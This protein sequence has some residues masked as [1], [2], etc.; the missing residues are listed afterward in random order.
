[1]GPWIVTRDELGRADDLRIDGTTGSVSGSTVNGPGPNT[2][3]SKAIA[4]NGIQVSNGALA[5]VIDNTVT[6]NDCDDAADGVQIDRN[7]VSGNDIGIY[8]QSRGT[9]DLRDNRAENNR[10]VQIYFDQG[11]ARFTNNRMLGGNIGLAAVSFT[12]NTADTVGYVSGGEIVHAA[13]QDVLIDNQNAPGPPAV[14]LVIEDSTKC[15]G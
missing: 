11:T 12:G 10:S 3:L 5:H 8:V 6:G 13:P 7:V 9:T 15:D 1:M 4:P 14:M 2:M